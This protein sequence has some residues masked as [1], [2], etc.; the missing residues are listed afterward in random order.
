MELIQFKQITV[1]LCIYVKMIDAVAIHVDDQ[2]EMQ[3]IK[4]TLKS[5]FRLKDMSRLRT[6]L[7]GN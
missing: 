6:L 2:I 4:E 7:S 3:Q 5:C 1:D